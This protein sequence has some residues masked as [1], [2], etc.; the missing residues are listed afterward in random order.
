MT[1]LSPWG[2]H[3]EEASCEGT[4]CS[5]G[6]FLAGGYPHSGRVAEAEYNGPHTACE[7]HL[8]QIRMS[9][10]TASSQSECHQD[11]L[12]QG[13]KVPTAKGRTGEGQKPTRGLAQ[14]TA[15]DEESGVGRALPRP[16]YFL[17]GPIIC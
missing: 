15:G 13:P 2:Q 9:G 14:R 1:G 12:I 10:D 4:K 17:L 8:G 5:W 3:S 6:H 7:A 11:I 16:E